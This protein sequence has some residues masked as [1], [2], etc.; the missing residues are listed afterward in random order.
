MIRKRTNPFGSNVNYVLS[1]LWWYPF[2]VWKSNKL[3]VVTLY[4]TIKWW[5]R[6]G[7][8]VQCHFQQ[9][10]SYILAVKWWFNFIYIQMYSLDSGHLHFLW[11]FLHKRYTGVWSWCPNVSEIQISKKKIK[12]RCFMVHMAQQPGEKKSVKVRVMKFNTTFNNISVVPWQSV[13]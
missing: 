9:Y 12:H 1:C 3:L 2:Q 13:L 4:R 8:S 6:V 11:W 7:Y 10:F 5:F